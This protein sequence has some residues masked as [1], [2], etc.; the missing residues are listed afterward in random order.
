MAFQTTTWPQM[1][2]KIN[3]NLTISFLARTV[4]GRLTCQSAMVKSLRVPGSRGQAPADRMLWMNVSWNALD[5]L[6][7][8]CFC[9][10]AGSIVNYLQLL[11][12]SHSQL[13]PALD[14]FQF[15]LDDSSLKFYGTFSQFIIVTFL[16]RTSFQRPYLKQ[17]SSHLHTVSFN[18]CSGASHML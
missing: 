1:T 8:F 9:I 16:R 7:N 15:F 2:C 10:K 11:F 17:T 5:L 18:H 6:V 3:E 13:F 12:L 4:K 14:L